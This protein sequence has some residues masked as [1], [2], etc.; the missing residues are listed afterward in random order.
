MIS[1]CLCLTVFVYCKSECMCA[2]DV[3]CV[4]VLSVIDF[5]HRSMV[6]QLQEKKHTDRSTVVST[7]YLLQCFETAFAAGIS[8][9]NTL[10]RLSK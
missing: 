9:N 6:S 4:C 10:N 7:S 5:T 1:V 2:Y 3:A 8:I